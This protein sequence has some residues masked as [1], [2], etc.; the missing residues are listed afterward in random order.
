MGWPKNVVLRVLSRDNNEPLKNVVLYLTISTPSKNPF[1]IGPLV[2][3]EHGGICLPRQKI[4]SDINKALTD[5]PMDYSSTLEKSSDEILVEIP[6]IRDLQARL[7]RLLRFY[8]DAAARL[9]TLI[10]SA[11]NSREESSKTQISV[12]DLVTIVIAT[13][14]KKSIHGFRG[15]TP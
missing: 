5:T 15:D 1:S 9:K 3:D 12:R 13:P 2:T 14:R 11:A 6:S 7:L 4:E 8:P 10:S